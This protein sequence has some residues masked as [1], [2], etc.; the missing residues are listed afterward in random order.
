MIRGRGRGSI[1]KCFFWRVSPNCRKLCCNHMQD[2]DGLFKKTQKPDE[3]S[4]KLYGKIAKKK[5][6]T[7]FKKLTYF[8]RNFARFFR[9]YQNTMIL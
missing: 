7:F 2:Y 4:P 5:H 3:F 9:I 6:E 8:C 1:E